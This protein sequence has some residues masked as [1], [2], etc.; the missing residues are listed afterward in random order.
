[1]SIARWCRPAD[2]T[3]H[4]GGIHP[5]S[6]HGTRACKLQ[7]RSHC[8]PLPRACP[9]APIALRYMPRKSRVVPGCPTEGTLP[10]VRAGMSFGFLWDAFM[11]I[12]GM[13]SICSASAVHDGSGSAERMHSYEWFPCRA[14]DSCIHDPIGEGRGAPCPKGDS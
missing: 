5:C 11:P 6:V 1:R 13:I 8:R 7:A 2:C 3:L 10:N 4:L 9:A 12:D 14:Y